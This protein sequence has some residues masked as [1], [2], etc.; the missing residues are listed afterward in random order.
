MLTYGNVKHIKHILRACSITLW[1]WVF[2][3]HFQKFVNKSRR[4]CL[5]TYFHFQNFAHKKT[6]VQT[7]TFD[8]HEENQ[9]VRWIRDGIPW[10]KPA[11]NYLQHCKHLYGCLIKW[12]PIQ[13]PRKRRVLSW[14]I[15][16]KRDTTTAAKHTH[17]HIKNKEHMNTNHEHIRTHNSEH[18]NTMNKEQE[19]NKP[20]TQRTHNKPIANQRTIHSTQC[21]QNKELI[22][23]TNHTQMTQLHYKTQMTTQKSKPKNLPCTNHEHKEKNRTQCAQTMNTCLLHVCLSKKVIIKWHGQHISGCPTST[24]DTPNEASMLWRA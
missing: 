1:F 20:W 8:F 10:G 23:G 14:K 5:I 16:K 17:T 11:R 9:Q 6:C 21:A 15:A 19:K 13:P 2:C 22:N 12:C 7:F 3:F 24:Y 4:L 18:M